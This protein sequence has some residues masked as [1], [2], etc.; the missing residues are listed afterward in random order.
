[1]RSSGRER[2]IFVQDVYADISGDERPDNSRENSREI[3]APEVVTLKQNWF[4]HRVGQG[5]GEAAPET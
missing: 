4:A 3:R 5:I 2:R 1:M